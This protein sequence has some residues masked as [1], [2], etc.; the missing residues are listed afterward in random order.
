MPTGLRRWAET[1]VR[2]EQIVKFG[3]FYE[4]QLPRPWNDTSEQELISD[5]LDQ[6]ELAD[7]LG[8]QY[9]WEVEH[10][11]LEEYSHS[12]APE[13]FLAAASQRTR[14]MRIGHGVV[15][16]APAYNHPARIA[17]RIAMLDLV[18]DGRVEFGS[19]E[20]SSE[21]ELAGFG[22][23]RDTKRDAWLEGL[24]VA[25]RCMTETP[26]GG[27]DGRFVSM[28][29]RNV[30]PKPVQKPHPPL[31]VACSRRDTILLAARKG[32]GALSFA[33]VEPEDAGQ[34][35][36][37]YER[38][39]R[40]QCVPVG[41][42]VNPQV[43]C[44]TPMMCAPREE[45]ALDRGLEGANF[46]GYSLAHFYVF[47]DHVPATTDVWGE[48]LHRRGKMGY[49]PEAA[50]A[51]RHETLGAKVAAGDT[52]GLRGAIG[53]PAQLREFLRR[54]EEAGVDQLIFVMQAG[55]NRHEHIMESLELFG[56][57]VLP[58]FVERDEAATETKAAKWAPLIE[59]ALARR[60][61]TDPVMPPDYVM[62]AIPRQMV[63]AMANEPAQQWLEALAD[64]QAAGVLDEEFQ[65][66]VDG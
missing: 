23:D 1:R 58:E 54:Y 47:G 30:V 65:R 56:T 34:W 28:P 40:E 6:I 57:Q 64:K 21:A 61:R 63:D 29:P 4:H 51:G 39:L 38:V 20:S 25:I 19:G 55:K 13:V 41:L 52:T 37:D 42:S 59:A 15:Q 60:D 48:F 26:F 22:I 27:V 31:W 7:R 18:S 46:F 62:R 36:V 3:V 14:R 5:A 49:S 17:E 33:F 32:I 35:V 12:S 66:L 24:E 11:F 8:V 45:D 10:H 50:L 16:T 2:S 53:T 44:V 43:A 9:L